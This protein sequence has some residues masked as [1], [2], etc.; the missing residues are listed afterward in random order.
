MSGTSG[1][2]LRV[3]VRGAAE[4]ARESAEAKNGEGTCGNENASPGL[5][6]V[7]K[8]TA[9]NGDTSA[10]GV[11]KQPVCVTKQA[12]FSVKADQLPQFRLSQPLWPLPRHVW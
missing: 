6:A 9:A 5:E 1:R 10:N 7:S 12:K 8:C 3:D 4:M 11:Q 2:R